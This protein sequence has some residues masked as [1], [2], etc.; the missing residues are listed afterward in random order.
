MTPQKTTLSVLDRAKKDYSENFV[1]R[2]EI[3]LYL[4]TSDI[5]ELLLSKDLNE[6]LTLAK[7][8]RFYLHQLLIASTAH[9]EKIDEL[10]NMLSKIDTQCN[11]YR[12]NG[13]RTLWTTLMLRYFIGTISDDGLYNIFEGRKVEDS[14]CWQ[15]AY[16]EY[17]RRVQYRKWRENNKK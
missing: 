1:T 4:T 13:I 9:K 8:F 5:E 15:V 16:E 11:I 6:D 12:G 10:K 3:C 7:K 17:Q 2:E 14:Y